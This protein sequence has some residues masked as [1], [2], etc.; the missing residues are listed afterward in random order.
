VQAVHSVVIEFLDP[1][2]LA[3]DG[4]SLSTYADLA[5]YLGRAVGVPTRRHYGVV[6]DDGQTSVIHRWLEFFVPT[7]GWVPADPALGDGAFGE[8]MRSVA[9]LYGDDPA[10][11]SLGY[12]D[13]RRVTVARDGELP[14]PMYPLGERVEPEPSWAP[15][16]TWAESPGSLPE[17]LE[18]RWEAPELFGWFAGTASASN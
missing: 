1:A 9:E 4:G 7:V 17:N 14:V 12:L 8:A 5:A 16:A 18:L 2:G 3:A 11:G 13:A 6:L 10:S 15:G